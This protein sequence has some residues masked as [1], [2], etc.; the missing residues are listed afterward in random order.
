MTASETRAADEDLDEPRFEYNQGTFAAEARRQRI[1]RNLRKVGAYTTLSV[2]V[3]IAVGPAV[4]LIS[5]AF[6]DSVS[7][8]SYP[9]EWLPSEPT[10]ENYRFLFR[11]TEYLRWA[12][13]TLIY[14]TGVTLIALVTNTLAA[15]AFATMKFPGHRT[16]FFLVLATMMIPVAAVLAPTYLTVRMIGGWPIIGNFIDLDT[17]GGL[18]LPSAV[19]PLGVFMMRQFIETLPSGLYEAARLDGASEWRILRKIVLPL[20]KPAL[21]VLGIFV[22]MLTWASYLWPLVAATNNDHRVLTVG[23]QSLNGQFVTNWGVMA[24]AALLTI[25][26][27]TIVFLFFQKWFVQASMAGALKQ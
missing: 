9:P 7:L 5:P 14:A 11:H 12:V 27:V 23:I 22:F 20:L 6:R 24:A 26:P 10:I 17:Y 15:Y 16:L 19:S 13:N 2:F 4:Y 3:V 25:I 1:S 21:V 8:F 18:I